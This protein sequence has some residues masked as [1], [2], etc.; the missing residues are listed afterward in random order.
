MDGNTEMIDEYL[1][2]ASDL[3]YPDGG[4]H[5]MKG[6]FSL[7]EEAKAHIYKMGK[8][9]N[10]ITIKGDGYFETVAQP[11]GS[12]L[13]RPKWIKCSNRLP[14]ERQELLMTYNDLVMEG[15]FVNGK[16]YHPSVCA[17]VEGYCNCDEQEGITHWMPLP[18]I[19][20]FDHIYYKLKLKLFKF[21]SS[22]VHNAY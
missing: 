12:I 7:L 10:E 8:K 21:Y 13:V 15:R 14:E 3:F 4:W 9:D 5:D 20:F 16:F 19:P 1:V 2:F 17:H 6:C 18:K 22:V 11:D